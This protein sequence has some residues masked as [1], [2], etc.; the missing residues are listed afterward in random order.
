[1]SQENDENI[2]LQYE[3]IQVIQSIYSDKTIPEFQFES[4]ADEQE[5]NLGSLTSISFLINLNEE[6]YGKLQIWF[7]FPKNY[8]SCEDKEA[9]LNYRIIKSNFDQKFERILK[10]LVDEKVEEEYLEGEAN[11]LTVLEAAK[12]AYEEVKEKVEKF[13][14]ESTKNNEIS[15]SNSKDSPSRLLRYYIYSHHI[16]SKTKRKN[17]CLYA[18]E[19][20][21]YGFSKPGKPGVIIMEGD[22]RYVKEWW[23][24]VKSWNWQHIEV[25]HEEFVDKIIFDAPVK[26]LESTDLSDLNKLLQSKNLGHIF[27][28]FF[29]VEGK[30]KEGEEVTPNPA[31][32]NA[33]SKP[34][35][36][37]AH[38]ARYWIWTHHVYDGSKRDPKR[39]NVI[40]LAN[41]MSLS[42]FSVPCKPGYILVEGPKNS[43]DTYYQEIKSWG[44]RAIEIRHV[45]ENLTSNDLKFSGPD[46]Q[47]SEMTELT[48]CMSETATRKN[49][50]NS[51]KFKEFLSKRG[52][53][54]VFKGL[55]KL[56]DF[57]KVV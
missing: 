52:C 1:M 25:K 9:R 14:T 8:P 30:L 36:S 50:L 6:E 23:R 57:E 34:G 54:H 10:D 47:K 55:F 44:W 41:D 5:F 18:N 22:E 19:K 2:T 53:E 38:F 28:Q 31:S 56:G 3:E 42:G 43:C 51:S 26:E 35:P 45:E 17:I 29:G 4:S 16:Y 46:A 7:K 27:K 21:L 20:K 11:V 15:R 48:F 24:I 39:K 33:T 37:N 32:P 13:E 49:S 12:E 40:T